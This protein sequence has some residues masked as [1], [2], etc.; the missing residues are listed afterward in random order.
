VLLIEDNP[1]DAHLLR[2]MLSSASA[3]KIELKHATK[4]ENGLEWLESGEFDVLLLDLGLPGSNGVG[5]FT[6]A[7]NAAPGVPILVFTGTDV[8]TTVLDC[9]KAGAKDYFVKSRVDSDSLVQAIYR[10]SGQPVPLNSEV[11]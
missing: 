7:A 2:Q 5:T 10:V 8:T 1:G 3:P 9:I 4:L 11:C 6:R